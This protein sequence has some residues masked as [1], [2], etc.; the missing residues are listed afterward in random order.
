MS[1]F[2]FNIYLVQDADNDG[3]PDYVLQDTGRVLISTKSI[4]V[5]TNYRYIGGQAA[6][7]G[8]P[9]LTF[10]IQ[11]RPDDT[12]YFLYN[13]QTFVGMFPNREAA[14]G[15]LYGVYTAN[16]GLDDGFAA[17]LA[18]SLEKGSVLDDDING[19]R[20]IQPE[21][22]DDIDVNLSDYDPS[23]LTTG[24]TAFFGYQNVNADGSLVP[25][26]ITMVTQNMTAVTASAGG[27]QGFT[28]TGAWIDI[29]EG[30]GVRPVLIGLNGTT[31]DIKNAGAV[32][33][34]PVPETLTGVT[35]SPAGPITLYQGSSQLF[36]ATATGTATDVR[37]QFTVTGDTTNVT[38]P[39][40]QLSTNRNYTLTWNDVVNHADDDVKINVTASSFNVGTSVSAP[41]IDVTLDH[42]ETAVIDFDVHIS[43]SSGGA[44]GNV[45]LGGTA[46]AVVDNNS[47]PDPLDVTFGYEWYMEVPQITTLSITNNGGSIP[48]PL[49]RSTSV[50]LDRVA[51]LLQNQRANMIIVGDSITNTQQQ[52]TL[53]YGRATE[54]KPERFSGMLATS[55]GGYS[56]ATGLYPEAPGSDITGVSSPNQNNAASQPGVVGTVH[57]G[58]C[59]APGNMPWN[60]LTDTTGNADGSETSTGAHTLAKVTSVSTISDACV[61]N[62]QDETTY[63]G[64]ASDLTVHTLW[65]AA[66]D[67]DIYL[68]YRAPYGSTTAVN[69][70]I[71]LTTGWNHVTHEY[72]NNTGSSFPGNRLNEF[73]SKMDTNDS[74]TLSAVFFES[75][76]INGLN[77]IYMGGGTWSAQ[78]HIPNNATDADDPNGTVAF[79]RDDLIEEV[80]KMQ[81]TNVVWIH[82]GANGGLDKTRTEVEDIMDRYRAR[83]TAAGLTGLK[84][85]V[86]TTWPNPYNDSLTDWETLRT[87]IRDLPNNYADVAVL[88]VYQQILDRHGDFA[89]FHTADL[90]DFVHPTEAGGQDISADQWAEI[91]AV[92]AL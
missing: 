31:V 73:I 59:I 64:S 79:F 57:A 60:A 56:K 85:V 84:F 16:D 52:N 35:V 1:T 23:V 58:A 39:L 37:Y 22:T 17:W 40:S 45:E 3:S 32:L 83:H 12:W 82:V 48:A 27:D 8:A 72:T 41:E 61:G 77:Y 10:N 88:D 5:D 89:T 11:K 74:V 44:Q 53:A 25:I 69:E 63:W 14:L 13:K 15:A 46:F 62:D 19:L 29:A 36:R 21:G 33:Y 81:Q 90:A 71:A 70:D 92:A 20:L 68:R 34:K 43:P 7:K 26:D 28:D 6:K 9:P 49:V 65:Y 76:S 87:Y 67:T 24:E 2:T 86:C 55:N 54:W 66:Q 4:T 30:D 18:D 50:G 38:S 91:A 42:S 78:T 47:T 80:M 51:D 75:P